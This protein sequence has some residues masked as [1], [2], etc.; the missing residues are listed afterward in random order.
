MHNARLRVLQKVC[1]LQQMK[2]MSPCNKVWAKI[3]TTHESMHI[4]AKPLALS[5]NPSQ[6]LARTCRCIHVMFAR[7]LRAI[8]CCI[9][10][11]PLGAGRGCE[12]E[13][14]CM[15]REAPRFLALEL[16]PVSF[17]TIA[18]YSF[19]FVVWGCD[20]ICL[21]W[22]SLPPQRWPRIAVKGIYRHN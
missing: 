1:A 14:A 10:T 22:Y 12:Y 15:S 9:L 11:T 7:S 8:Q 5:H 16:N 2:C 20:Q 21:W 13:L 17:S 4:R 18:A 19:V 6:L 3:C